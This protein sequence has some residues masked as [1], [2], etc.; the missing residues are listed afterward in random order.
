MKCWPFIESPF[1]S[2]LFIAN[3]E[4]FITSRGE[5]SVPPIEFTVDTGYDGDLLLNNELYNS[6]GFSMFEEAQ[7]EWDIGELVTGERIPLRSS[8]SKTRL[9][10]LDF[11]ARIETFKGNHE[12]LIG[13]G[14]L[15]R[16][17]A[18]INGFK[19]EFCCSA[20]P[21]NKS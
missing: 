21:A 12:N 7:E 18:E 9:E 10:H 20:L 5:W 8:H 4:L 16:F 11:P 6:L 2:P 1:R 19:Q 17:H 13:R 3:L 14:L 15:R